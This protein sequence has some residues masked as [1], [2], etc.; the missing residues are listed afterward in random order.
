MQLRKIARQGITVRVLISVIFVF[1]ISPPAF[2]DIRGSA[3]DFSGRAWSDGMICTPCHTPH[4][5][6][7]SVTDAPLWNHTVT[8][9]SYT[10]YSSPTLQIAPLQP[11]SVSKLC[12][13]CHDGTVAVESFGGNTGT[14]LLEGD[15]LVGTNLSNDH[16]VSIYWDHQTA[17]TGTGLKCNN[18]HALHGTPRLISVLP[19]FDHYVECAT[20]HDV[21]NA[22][23]ANGKLLRLPKT[24]SQLCLYCHGK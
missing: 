14:T 23:P 4:N 19:F 13:S 9:A 10:L 21:H 11:R 1:S 2:A 22:Y 3:H 5:A 8:S 16:P 12:L 20:C 7:T 17:S 15:A 18:C 6:D 24:N